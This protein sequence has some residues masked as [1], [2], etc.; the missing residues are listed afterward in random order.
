MRYYPDLPS[1]RKI[2]AFKEHLPKGR[3]FTHKR[4]IRVPFRVEGFKVGIPKPFNT[5]SYR[6]L[7]LKRTGWW[8]QIFLGERFPIWLFFSKGLKPPTRQCC[9]GLFFQPVQIIRI[10]DFAT[11]SR[12]FITPANG[13]ETMFVSCFCPVK[14][15]CFINMLDNFESQQTYFDMFGPFSGWTCF[16]LGNLNQTA[17]C[18][19]MFNKGNLHQ[20]MT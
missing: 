7:S 19:E 17:N 5:S 14:G 2:S 3:N 4:K 11:N 10:C 13:F 1:V 9:K 16:L 15:F 12:W 8:F 6:L 18:T 20:K